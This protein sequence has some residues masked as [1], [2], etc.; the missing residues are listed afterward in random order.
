[1]VEA[2]VYRF[3]AKVEYRN[4]GDIVYPNYD[5]IKGAMVVFGSI[6]VAAS[7]LMDTFNFGDE[8][9]EEYLIIRDVKLRYLGVDDDF[10]CKKYKGGV[11][12]YERGRAKK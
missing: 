9:D 3:K 11:L 10:A 1:M 12:Y 7:V 8:E 4:E 2:S 6:D 5:E